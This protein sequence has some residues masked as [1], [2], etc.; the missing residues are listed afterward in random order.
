MRMF[1]MTGNRWRIN[2]KWINY[3]SFNILQIFWQ[4]VIPSADPGKGVRRLRIIFFPSTTL[5][6]LFSVYFGFPKSFSVHSMLALLLGGEWSNAKPIAENKQMIL[7]FIINFGSVGKI[8]AWRRSSTKYADKHEF[9][10]SL[11]ITYIY[12]SNYKFVVRL[13]EHNLL[14]LHIHL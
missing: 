4:S 9:M 8:G 7:Y 11:R 6:I 13:A 2:Q 3:S 5:Q 10:P 14:L 1:F 12:S